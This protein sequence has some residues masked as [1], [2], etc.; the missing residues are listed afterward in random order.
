M[1][2]HGDPS[3]NRHL[4]TLNNKRNSCIHVH[5]YLFV[6][7]P[8]HLFHWFNRYAYSKLGVSVSCQLFHAWQILPCVTCSHVIGHTWWYTFSIQMILQP[9]IGIQNIS[10]Y[11]T[12]SV[13]VLLCISYEKSFI[14]ALIKCNRQTNLQLR[15]VVLKNWP[16]IGWDRRVNGIFETK[17]GNYN[18]LNVLIVNY[19]GR[20]T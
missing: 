17:G 10:C 19:L 18:T 4:P 15:K 13:C 11:M 12:I 6:W 1:M 14:L 2:R 20:L 8:V 5:R 3:T 16:K 7:V 9:T